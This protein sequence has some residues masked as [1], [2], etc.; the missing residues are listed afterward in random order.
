MILVWATQHDAP[1]ERVLAALAARG[2]ETC[3]IDEYALKTLRYDLV[4]AQS[5]EGW[6]EAAGRRL[7]IEDV[8]GI[9]LRPGEPVADD[10]R[11]A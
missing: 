1:A 4:F 3:Q 7:A 11:I 10:A 6:I 9:Y 5:P 2:V 8:R